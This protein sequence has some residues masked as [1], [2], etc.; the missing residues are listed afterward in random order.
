M[1][2]GKG[3][4]TGTWFF[5]GRAGSII[6]EIVC[7]FLEVSAF[8]EHVF[9]SFQD[10]F[11]TKIR[12]LVSYD[13]LL[14]KQERCVGRFLGFNGVYNKN[15][16]DFG[17]FSSS[18]SVCCFFYTSGA[19]SDGCAAAAKGPEFNWVLG[20]FTAVCRRDKVGYKR[21]CIS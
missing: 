5:C 19:Q 3:K 16:V 1:G 20:L 17:T 21:V 13:E 7:C 15:C 9:F 14:V 10:M 11:R 18:Y 4:P 8:I 6:L 12:L 2:G